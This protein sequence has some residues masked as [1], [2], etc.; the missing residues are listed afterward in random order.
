MLKNQN[1]YIDFDFCFRILENN[2]KMIKCNSALLFHSLG[3][4]KLRNFFGKQISYTNHSAIRRYYMTR[5]RIYCWSKYKSVAGNFI[6][7]DKQ[8][9][10]N[11]LI[12]IILFEDDKLFK[13]KMIIRGIKDNKN[14]NFG[15]LNLQ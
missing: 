6:K 13:I 15:K 12:K 4:T 5:N 8:C 10:K 3:D 14:N 1:N 9:F 7:K 2:Y 11:E